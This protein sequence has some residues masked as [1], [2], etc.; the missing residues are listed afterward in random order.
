[1]AYDAS[2]PLAQVIAERIV[3]KARDAGLALQLASDKNSDDLRLIRIPIL[4]LDARLALTATADSLR[5]PQPKLAESSSEDLYIAE[6]TILQ[7]QRVIPLLHVRTSYTLGANVRNW[8]EALNGSW[9]LGEVWLSA[10]K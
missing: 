10:T 5:L 7:S 8:S 3:L 6:S 1:L 9:H 2:D 4:S